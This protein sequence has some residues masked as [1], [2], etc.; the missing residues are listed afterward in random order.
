LAGELARNALTQK[1]F[2]LAKR[3]LAAIAKGVLGR[4]IDWAASGVGLKWF[5]Q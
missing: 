3:N 5:V 1:V 4:V 2:E